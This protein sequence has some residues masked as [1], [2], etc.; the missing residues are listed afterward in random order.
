MSERGSFRSAGGRPGGFN[1]SGGKGRPGSKDG[2]G[3]FPKRGAQGGDNRQSRPHPSRTSSPTPRVS[4]D[5]ARQVAFDVLVS[6]SA[7]D[8]YANLVLPQLLAERRITGRDAA[9]ATE[10]TYGTLRM[11]LF[12]D[13]VLAACSDRPISEV[14]LRLKE[15]LRLGAYQLLFMRVP[16]HA[17]VSAT[18]DV[19]R[20]TVGEGQAKFANAILRKISER[21]EAQWTEL[22]VPDATDQSVPALSVRHSHPEWIVR[23]L[24]D[25]LGEEA[26]I[27]E[28]LA[29][30]NERPSVHLAARPGRITASE[31]AAQTGGDVGAYAPDAVY[32]PSGD[33]SG[34]SALREGR[35]HVQD[36]GSQLVAR[37]LA[38]VAMAHDVHWLDLCAG[39]GG[40]AAL[41]GALAAQNNADVTAVEV[42][43][44]RADLVR[45][46]V[47]N[48]P[49]NVVHT[50]GRLVGEHQALPENHF[51]RV[52]VDAPCTGLGALRRRPEARW[53]KQP[54]DIPALTKLQREL[55]AAAIRAARPGGVIAYVTCSPHKAET[56]VTVADA[57]RRFDVAALDAREFLPGVPELGAGPF[58]QLWPHRHGTDAM[59]LALLR[60]QS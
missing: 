12:L 39:P 36:E 15:V 51:D 11:Q 34:V 44:H 28:A 52:L 2:R 24:A 4:V 45:G 16:S 59:F 47:M 14:D 25:A 27:A 37:A 38:S 22:I 10:L 42:T 6:V 31:L 55:L 53:R 8:A 43:E 29:A 21:D 35:A 40:K 13:A 26:E 1:K 49:V 32:L 23:A 57:L 18:V 33:P 41:L 58:V 56:V 7:R 5:P 20:A 48:M 60:K 9:F 46:A 50:D 17:G 54:S 19:A 30:N 3:S